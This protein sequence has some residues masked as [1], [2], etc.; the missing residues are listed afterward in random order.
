MAD[1]APYD[2]MGIPADMPADIQADEGGPPDCDYCGDGEYLAFYDPPC[3]MCAPFAEI[4]AYLERG[5]ELE[6]AA[7]N[8]GYQTAPLLDQLGIGAL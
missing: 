4:E 2:Q 5:E 7:W 6:H 1:T 3:P 8:A